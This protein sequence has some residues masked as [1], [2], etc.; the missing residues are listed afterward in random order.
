MPKRNSP[1]LDDRNARNAPK[2]PHSESPRG[3]DLA[4]REPM[5]RRDRY[6]NASPQPGKDERRNRSV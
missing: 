2:Q 4:E 1:P 5:V 3:P 6:A